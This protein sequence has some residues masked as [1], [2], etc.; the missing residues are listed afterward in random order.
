MYITNMQ[1]SEFLFQL[2]FNLK[3]LYQK[4]L[5]IPNISFQQA[6]TLAIIDESGL[7]MS[8]LSKMLGIDNSTTTRLI[9][10]LEKKGLVRRRRDDFDSRSLKVFLTNDGEK[11]YTSI[12]LQLEEISFEIEKQLNK[13][14]REQIVEAG[15]ALNWALSKKLYK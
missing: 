12:E 8:R 6:L 11:I 10:G 3:A 14:N 1:Y 4:N 9:D 15:I 7:K 5:N 13:K 2:F